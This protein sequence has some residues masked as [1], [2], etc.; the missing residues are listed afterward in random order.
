VNGRLEQLAPGEAASLLGIATESVDAGAGLSTLRGGMMDLVDA[1]AESV[2][3][4]GRVAT[5]ST[6]TRLNRYRA[7][8]QIERK[9]GPP[10]VADAVILATP[11]WETSS[12]LAPVIGGVAELRAIRH[13]AS[14]TVSLAA[15]RD[16]IDHPLDATG[17]VGETGSMFRA[18]TFSSSKFEDRAPPGWALLRLYFRVEPDGLSTPDDVWIGYAR[19]QVADVLGFRAHSGPAWVSRWARVF[20]QF[21]DRHAEQVEQLRE[22][23][24]GAGVR[25]E[26]A[27]AATGAIGVEGAVRSGQTA[28]ARTRATAAAW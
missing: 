13:S 12:L 7:G 27:G 6:A 24:D 14:I 18:C 26:L 25:L 1:L 28:A 11:V 4:C 16:Q 5:R 15:E 23:I 17:F 3:T 9:D 21:P 22:R 8:W 20:P 2:G 19:Q 10:V